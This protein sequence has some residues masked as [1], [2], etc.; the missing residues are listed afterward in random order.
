MGKTKRWIYV[1]SIAAVTG[2]IAF[3]LIHMSGLVA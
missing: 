3:V 1:A 2:F